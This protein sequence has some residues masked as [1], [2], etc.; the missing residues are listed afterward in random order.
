VYFTCGREYR[1]DKMI[2]PDFRGVESLGPAF[3]EEAFRVLARRNAGVALVPIN[4]T[5]EVRRMIECA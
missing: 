5:C 1:F 3:A 2:V 4:T